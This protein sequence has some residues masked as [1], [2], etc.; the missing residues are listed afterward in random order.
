MHEVRNRPARWPWLLVAAAVAVAGG[1][2]L[3]PRPA[4]PPEAAAP[5][6][7][8][9]LPPSPQQ[10][11]DGAEA[12]PRHPVAPPEDAADAAIPALADSDAAVRDALAGLVADPAVLELLLR[13]HLVQ[14]LVVMADNLTQARVPRTALAYRPLPGSYAVAE[15]DGVQIADQAANAGRYAPYVAALTAAD[16]AR[17][18]ALYRRFYPLF[19]QAWE[20]LG[21]PPAYF[22]DRL[23][24][25]LDHLLQVPEPAQPPELVQDAHGRLRY[26]DPALESASIGHKALLRLAPGHRAEVKAWLAALRRALAR[27]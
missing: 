4:D 18:A 16:P 5:P 17:V 20:E 15:Q 8:G 10:A 9:G 19:Q 2:L 1:W 21:H 13:D 23:V 6:A 22:N 14:R 12:P 7:P 27:P 24:A 25:V 11:G 26:A 3:W